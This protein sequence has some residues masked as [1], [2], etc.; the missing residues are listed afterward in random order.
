MLA[1]STSSPLHRSEKRPTQPSAFSYLFPESQ[2]LTHHYY[3]SFPPQMP[4]KP[5]V[6]SYTQKL[7]AT[8]GTTFKYPIVNPT[9]KPRKPR[10]RQIRRVVSPIRSR[11]PSPTAPPTCMRRRMTSSGYETVCETSPA[12]APEMSSAVLVSLGRGGGSMVV[13]DMG[14]FDGG[15]VVYGTRRGDERSQSPTVSWVRKDMPA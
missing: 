7:T 9:Q 3:S 10:S 5:L 4:K 12:R 11:R 1:H 13:C 8:I 14:G 6:R 2:S 15:R